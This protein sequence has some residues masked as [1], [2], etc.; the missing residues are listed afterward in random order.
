MAIVQDLYSVL[1]DAGIS[2]IINAGTSGPAIDITG[3][4][5][6][7]RSVA[8]GAVPS[9]SDSDVDDFVYQ[10]SAT[11]IAYQILPD[12][13]GCMFQIVLD[14]DIGDFTVGQIGLMVG[15]VML[16][17]TVLYRGENKWRSNLPGVMGNALVFNIIL[18]I[19]NVQSCINLTLMRSLYASL[20]EVNTESGLPPANTATYNTYLVRNH[21][22]LG[23][24]VIATVRNGIW[25][26]AVN[27]YFAGHG[28]NIV[29]VGTAA[30]AAGIKIN[31][32]V[33]YDVDEKKYYPADYNN[34]SK[35]PV[36]V[37]IS[38]FEIMT[39]G[40]IQRYVN[41]DIWP[42]TITPGQIY[43]TGSISTAG[44]P[45]ENR[46]YAAYGMAVSSDT[47][48]VNFKF[49]QH[50]QSLLDAVIGSNPINGVAPIDPS[51]RHPD[52]TETSPGFMS[53]GDKEKLDSLVLGKM[54]M[55]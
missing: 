39:V 28:Q 17:K 13:R 20:P 7:S 27:R 52:A 4:R 32:T 36:G 51:H 10:G 2:A 21:T 54:S 35:H 44:R 19:S 15:S 18:E 12:G 11:Q 16:S 53:T 47:M 37:R 55:L 26:Y 43:Y 40:L 22:K 8:E 42:P 45:Q 30:F 14:E 24:S 9:K 49:T 50:S 25:L 6:G 33:Y 31:S 3:F 34:V 1:T 5:I 23:V 48:F 46:S 41:D 38:D 29:P